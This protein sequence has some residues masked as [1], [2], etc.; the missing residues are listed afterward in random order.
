MKIVY[1]TYHGFSSTSG[2]SKKMLYQIEALRTLGNEVSVCSYRVREDGHR[3]REIDGKVLSDFGVGTR[4]AMLKRISYGDIVS[5]AKSNGIELVYVRSFHNANPFTIHLFKSLRQLGIRVLMEIPTYPYDQEYEEFPLRQRLIQ[6]VDKVFRRRLASHCDGIVTFSDYKEIFGCPTIRIS[7]GISFEHIPLR[8]HTSA[9]DSRLH[10]LAVA[11]VHY[12]HGYD[13]LVEGL[14]K[15]Y[16][17]G[18]TRDIVFDIVGGIGKDMMYGCNHAQGIKPL[19]EQYGLEDRIILHGA[20]YGE[21]LDHYFDQADF[22]IGSL[23]RHRSGIDSIKTLKN[24]EYAA[25]GIAFMYSETD[26][27]FDH[28]PYIYKVEASDKPIDIRQLLAFIDN[29]Q[30]PAETI[31]QSIRPLSWTNQMGKCIQA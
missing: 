7:N 22:A 28:C 9:A 19:I 2:I 13:R 10:L 5:Y 29:C 23:A 26:S 1:L 16:A 21:A 8:H 20:Q 17:S 25:R 18:G 27:D 24:R 11:E 3:V 15:Y 30:I 14:G 31:R 12:W 6:L 4:A